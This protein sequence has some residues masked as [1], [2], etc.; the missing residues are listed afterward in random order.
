MKKLLKIAVFA[1]LLSSFTFPVIAQKQK[2]K[3]DY[4]KEISALFK[5]N[6][7]E[8]L[9]KAYYLAK[10]FLTA[11]PKE[12]GDNINKLKQFIKSNQENM[13]Y[14]LLDKGKLAEAFAAG[15]EVLTE[16]PENIGVLMN[17][18]YSGFDAQAKN[19][20]NSFAEVSTN[21]AKQTISLLE[22][23]KTPANFSPFKN[24]DD[25]IG[26]MY[27]VIGNFQK[28]TDAKES[29]INFYKATK[30]EGQVKSSSF[31]YYVIANYYETV[32]QKLATE[33]NA[34]NKSLT[35]EQ[36]K[37]E[38]D[39]V[40]KV[41]DLMLD[42]Y[43]RAIKFAEAENNPDKDNWKKRF[44]DVYKFRNKSDA[45]INEFMTLKNASPMP[46]PSAN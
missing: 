26:W 27:Y 1:I 19:K 39:K 30:Y 2:S 8:E 14:N 6:K 10:E 34:K 18:A 37:I 9:E 7:P 32:Y 5:I 45:G 35:E 31:P 43:A 44:T 42:A 13:F 22:S 20:D 46:D 41:L 29:A 33:Y 21:Y 36:N 4:L 24:K 23:G 3:D 16:N 38:L 25:T 12:K 28:D 40:N 17:L 15:K 11:Y